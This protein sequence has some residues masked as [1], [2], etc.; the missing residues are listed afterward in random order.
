LFFIAV[1]GML[2]PFFSF[3]LFFNAYVW[4]EKKEKK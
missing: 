2:F 1:W 3:S 4:N